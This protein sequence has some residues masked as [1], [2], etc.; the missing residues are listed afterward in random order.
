MVDKSIVGTEM[1]GS[2]MLVEQGKV[3]EFAKSILDDNP[4]YSEE[5][6]PLPP[7]FTMAMAH[8]PAPQGG[9]TAGLSKLGLDLLR[10]LHGGQEYEYLGEIKVGDKLTTRSKIADVYEKEGKR[11]GTLT[12]VTS[13]TTFTNQRGEDVL[14]A[15]TILVQTS[16]AAS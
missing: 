14:V 4:V 12:F 13:E 3:R 7:T 6:P 15:R 8:W 9:Q 10:V 2:W 16:K 11:G 5:D 1:G